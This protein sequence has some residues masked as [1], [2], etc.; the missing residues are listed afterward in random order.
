MQQR[1]AA[2]G[3]FLIGVMGYAALVYGLAYYSLP[4]AFII[5]GLIA[6]WWSWYVSVGARLQW[7]K[8]QPP[9]PTA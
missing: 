1:L 4:L 2:L 6:M 5:A 8:L 9:K 7:Q 3:I